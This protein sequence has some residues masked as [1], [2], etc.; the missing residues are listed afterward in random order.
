MSDSPI[1]DA[2][3]AEI[4]PEIPIAYVLMVKTTVS[5]DSDA[6]GYVHYYSGDIDTRLGLIDI[7]RLRTERAYLTETE[8]Q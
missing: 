1:T 6:T 8:D 2:I 5:D 4:G 7:L 3:S